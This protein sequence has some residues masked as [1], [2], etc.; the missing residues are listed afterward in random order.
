MARFSQ[1]SPD[2]SIGRLA[3]CGDLAAMKL[4]RHAATAG[5]ACCV[6]GGS[7]SLAS[8]QNQHGQCSNPE[9][10][11]CVQIALPSERLACTLDNSPL[12]PRNPHSHPLLLIQQ[13]LVLA[14]LALAL[15]TRTRRLL[16]PSPVVASRVATS[17]LGTIITLVT[18]PSPNN[19]VA[20]AADNFPGQQFEG[21]YSSSTESGSY[22]QSNQ[23][24]ERQVYQH[25]SVSRT[26]EANANF[27]RTSDAMKEYRTRTITMLT[28]TDDCD[29]HLDG[30]ILTIAP[31]SPDKF[32][33]TELNLD[34]HIGDI[35]GELVWGGAAVDAANFSN[36]CEK[37]HLDGT[38]LVALCRRGNEAI[39]VELDLNEHIAYNSARRCFMAIVPDAAFTELMSS[40]NWMNFTVITRPDM[41]AF[42]KNPAFQTAISGV[43]QRAIDEVMN[44]MRE[45]MA[46]A[47][48]EAVAAV[49]AK[50]EEYV[51]REMETLIKMA[52]KS[53]AYTGLGRLKMMQ[54]EQRR[55][56]N[57]FAPHIRADLLPEEDD[58]ETPPPRR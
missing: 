16:N 27:Q 44:Q 53:A 54:L 37:I 15:R 23:R 47:V 56:F 57:V 13:C 9:D 52:T 43:A 3:P 42:L 12:D 35:G 8:M 51:Q 6:H 39:Q 26:E 18:V 22:R 5:S 48:E 29:L 10:G 31:R 11:C 46:L 19:D 36:T 50:S 2:L 21:Q 33:S 1:H 40:A 14:L 28:L 30:V 4:I 58:R 7:R 24:Q 32:D 49:S 55:A 25:S 38:L 20:S 17:P 34:D 41:S 45:V